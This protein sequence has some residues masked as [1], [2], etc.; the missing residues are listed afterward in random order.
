VRQRQAL[1]LLAE[2]GASDI[3]KVGLAGR[4]LEKLRSKGGLLGVEPNNLARIA[5]RFLAEEDE[6][7]LEMEVAR[8]HE[9]L[10]NQRS[11]IHDGLAAL[12]FHW[13]VTSS[14]DPLMETALRAAQK[15]PAIERYHYKGHNKRLLP[16]PTDTAP[17][18]FHLYGHAGEPASVVLSETQLLDFLAALISKDPPLPNDLNAALTNGRLF[19]FL[20]FGLRQWYL[21]I[22]L[23]GLKVLR[24]NTR[25]VVLEALD[26]VASQPPDE[27]ILFYRENFKVDVYQEDVAEFVR[28][29]GRRYVPKQA[30]GTVEPSERPR[31]GRKV[32][33]CHASE[34]R[35]KAREVHDALGRAGLDPWLDRESLRGGDR[36]DE[37]IESTIKEVDYFVVLNSR[38]LEAKRYE[39]S[40]VNKEI[41]LA[42]QADEYRW[43]EFII[44]ALIDDTPLLPMLTKLQAVNLTQPDGMRDL[45][46]AIKRQDRA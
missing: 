40:Y 42:L 34:D 17:V 12:P 7:T 43:Q 11:A 28:E 44:P 32:F 27:T 13:I 14:H 8:W 9:E 3:A 22:L 10:K 36:W 15:T 16:E 4:L 1:R 41:K 46:R 6:V 33:V 5:Q 29:L 21:R 19:L 2:R 24:R 39:A 25:T 26:A 18:L 31:Q 45:I 38:A 23:H 30:A 35:A 20:G 37:R